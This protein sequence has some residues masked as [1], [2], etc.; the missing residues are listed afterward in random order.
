MLLRNAPLFALVLS[1]CTGPPE[2][3]PPAPIANT[4]QPPAP[5]P[6]TAAPEATSAAPA[7]PAPRELGAKSVEL[8]GAKAPV[9]LDL[10]AYDRDHGRVWVPVGDT[11]SVDVYEIATGKFVRVDGFKTVERERHGKKRMMGPSSVTIGDGVAYVGTRSTN[12]ICAV[13]E[14]SLRLA[15]CLKLASSPDFVTYV[16]SAKEVWVT[17][18]RDQ[19]LAV[20]DATK[21]AALK[22]KLVI[23][24]P[25]SVEGAAVDND[26]GLYYT[27]L[28]DKNQTLAVEIG[29]HTIKSTWDPG[30]GEGGPHGPSGAPVDPNGAP[31]S[32]NRCR[33]RPPR[34]ARG[35]W[36][37]PRYRHTPR[38]PGARRA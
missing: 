20:L 30:C 23:K 1:A 34:D 35:T 5:A 37:P 25:G 6:P 12:E 21:P 17:E 38:R 33:H 22:A 2:A 4:E 10:I 31:P 16:A 26:H 11:G 32:R 19:T 28:E 36:T 7:A 3:P 24:A 15:K 29:S 8:P 18:P 14:K 13:D 27:N 9:T